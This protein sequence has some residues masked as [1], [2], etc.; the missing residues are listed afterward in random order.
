MS[1]FVPFLV[2]FETMNTIKSIF[3]SIILV[4]FLLSCKNDNSNTSSKVDTKP[5][6]STEEVISKIGGK[7]YS[8]TH[9]LDQTQL[10]QEGN[11]GFTFESE[12]AMRVYIKSD[13]KIPID[14][15]KNVVYSIFGEESVKKVNIEL[16]K[17]DQSGENTVL[18]FVS[19]ITKED[20]EP[21][22]P[23]KVIAFPKSQIKGYLSAKI[24][25]V[26]VLSFIAN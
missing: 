26:A 20:T 7:D 12:N 5:T 11:I 8:K 3:L 18:H 25:S 17:I 2:K 9:E 4:L 16:D 21:Y 13:E 14:F 23:N 15:E 24:D 22:R 6:M 19:Y 1:I 10:V